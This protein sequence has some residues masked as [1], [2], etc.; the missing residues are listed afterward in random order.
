[1]RHDQIHSEESGTEA[2]GSRACL[3]L[4]T[5]DGFFNSRRSPGS[6]PPVH[7]ALCSAKLSPLSFFL[8]YSSFPHPF[9]PISASLSCLQPFI[10]SRAPTTTT[11][12][13]PAATPHPLH[14]SP[15]LHVSHLFSGLTSN[16]CVPP[17]P[18]PSLSFPRLLL[19]HPPKQR[20]A[21]ALSPPH[22]ILSCQGNLKPETFIGTFMANRLKMNG[23]NVVPL[24]T[25]QPH[26]EKYWS[27]RWMKYKRL[28]GFRTQSL[29]A[30]MKALS[31]GR[32]SVGVKGGSAEEKAAV[33]HFAVSR[34]PAEE[35]SAPDGS[36]VEAAPVKVKK[37]RMKGILN[38]FT[39]AR[40]AVFKM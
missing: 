33:D 14:I 30:A 4:F 11:N 27:S 22:N 7:V 20:S 29:L 21:I 16:G 17:P 13:S 39:R 19:L 1:M 36:S 26:L 2:A 8:L 37:I 28:P 18:P 31:E 35:T 24:Q 23:L 6:P 15:H 3:Q 25:C 5:Y 32:A 12:P 34:D 38:F 40:R 9:T 10:L